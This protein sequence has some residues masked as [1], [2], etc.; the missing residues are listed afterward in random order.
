ML[1][2][3]A[4]QPAVDR[5]APS[6]RLVISRGLGQLSNSYSRF[7]RIYFFCLVHQVH[8]AFFFVSS[9]KAGK[10]FVDSKNQ[11]ETAQTAAQAGRHVR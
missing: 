11:T 4:A 3:A 8:G 2:N 10:Y 7:R 6:R 5:M 9:P 1:H